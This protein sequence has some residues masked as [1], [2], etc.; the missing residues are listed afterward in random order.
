MKWYENTAKLADIVL[1]T[2]VRLAR[3]L[4]DY[5]FPSRLT[6]AGKD[7]VNAVVK[8]ALLCGDAAK[9]FDYVQMR[10][11]SKTQC[12]S[13][14]EKHLISPE[15]ASD[16]AGRALI[17]SK[18][19]DVSIMLCEEDHVRVQ[20]I[21]PG[22]SLEEAYD[23]ANAIDESLSA[24]VAIAFDE[25]LGYLTQ[26]PTNLGTGLRA[27]VMLHLPALARG[28]AMQRLSNTVA[29]LG[30]IL[31]GAYGEGSKS[32]GDIY[33]LSNQVTLGISEQAAIKNLESI[34]NQIVAQEKAAREALLKDDVFI[35]RIWRAYGILQ[36]AHMLSASEFM[37]LASLVRIGAAE[38]VLDVPVQTLTRLLVEMQPATLNCAQ[39][40]ACT[41]AERDVLRAKAVKEALR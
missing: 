4:K 31:R 28:G 1:S 27:S 9:D 35:D 15:F 32:V 36:S 3:N 24:K 22:L 30:L 13:L 5:P 18:D 40:R 25:R 29:K 17:L 19:E 7:E 12:V 23:K 38:G 34:A 16:S 2:R 26:C 33:Q 21:Y 20:V 10:A 8:D 11:L 14:A 41:A 37:E 39:G 6:E